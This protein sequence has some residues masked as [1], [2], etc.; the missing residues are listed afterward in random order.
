M[1]GL[2]AARATLM[3][4]LPP[5]GA[6]ITIEAGEEEVRR[7]LDGPWVNGPASRP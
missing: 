7:R 3:Q 6:M 1:C 4:Q 5:G 2:V